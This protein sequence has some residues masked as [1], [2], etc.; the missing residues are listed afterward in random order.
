M[1]K[2]AAAADL[3]ALQPVQVLVLVLVRLVLVLALQQV[4]LLVLVSVPLL[5]PGSGCCGPLV[6]LLA[7]E[8]T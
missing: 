5:H 6:A 1:L 8:L 4:P 3:L 7:A 2:A